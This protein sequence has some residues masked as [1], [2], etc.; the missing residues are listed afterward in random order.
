MWPTAVPTVGTPH[1]AAS[2]ATSGPASCR[3]EWTRR[4]AA[5]IEG[6]ERV[7]RQESVECHAFR[8]AERRGF[9]LDLAAEHVLADDV[10]ARAAAAHRRH[11]ERP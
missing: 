4:S 5:P 7:G 11:G 2:R 3:E 8:Q 1:A 6:K 9:A 10:E